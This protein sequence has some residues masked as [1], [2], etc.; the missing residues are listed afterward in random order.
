MIR[1]QGI[2]TQHS[3][4]STSEYILMI[5]C[6]AIMRWVPVSDCKAI[7]CSVSTPQNLHVNILRLLCYARCVH[8][9][10]QTLQLLAS[11]GTRTPLAKTLS[12]HGKYVSAKADSAPDALM[13]GA[14]IATST[15][16]R[17]PTSSQPEG[18]FA[19]TTSIMTKA[20]TIN[21][22]YHLRFRWRHY[23]TQPSHK[24]PR[25]VIRR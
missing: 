24:E 9:I 6:M 22:A 13:R 16:R 20:P 19:T 21:D 15:L 3:I 25:K 7:M 4:G 10:F 17:P 2:I 23:H 14:C 1:R 12:N 18:N 11:L 8:L 5:P